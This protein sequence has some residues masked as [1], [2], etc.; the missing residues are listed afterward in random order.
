MSDN[1]KA[2]QQL[3]DAESDP[4]TAT[5]A[6]N[7]ATAR[8]LIDIARTLRSIDAAFTRQAR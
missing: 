4:Q 3:V 5:D 6:V 1:L 8:A 7:E 2:A